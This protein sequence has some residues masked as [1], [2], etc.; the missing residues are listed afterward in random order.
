MTSPPPDGRGGID[1]EL[2]RRL[3]KSQFPQWSE[4]PV[5]PVEFDGWD[6]R[7]Y[8]LGEELTV[9]LP[10]A[11]GY[12]AAVAKEDRWLPRLAPHLPVP[13]P[14]PVATGRPGEGYPH[15]WSI[16]RWIPGETADPSRI[17]D[18]P[19]FARDVAGFLRAL[20]RIDAAG[21]PEPGP[22]CFHRGGPPGYY[23]AE[24]REALRRLATTRS[25]LG[26]IDFDRAAAV[27]QAALDAPAS[28]R[29]VWFHGDIA[30]GNLI[31]R[32]GRLAAVIDFGTCG[33]GDPACDLVISWTMFSGADRAAFREAIGQDDATWARARGWA[34]WKALIVLADKIDS[35][36][37]EAATQRRVIDEV[38]ADHRE[39]G[40]G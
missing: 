33:V 12:V 40:R 36:P 9:R 3:L 20:Q 11:P 4:L 32:D 17:A 14:E 7:T 2:V 8:R 25:D 13:V 10:S 31:V 23:D 5:R 35:D 19:G 34:I 26:R 39:F 15:P 29:T 16:R 24:T 28:T 6:N 18:L 38:I 27:W 1:A 22:H 37:G 30:H 21:G